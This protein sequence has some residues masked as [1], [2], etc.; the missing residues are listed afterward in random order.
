VFNTTTAIQKSIQDCL[1]GDAKETYSANG[2]TIS[3]CDCC[4]VIVERNK[5]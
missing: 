1:I 3:G 5:F 2:V 4:S